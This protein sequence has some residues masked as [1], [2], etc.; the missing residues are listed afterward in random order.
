MKVIVMFIVTGF[1]FSNIP[2]I[3]L[4]SLSTALKALSDLQESK[5]EV[6]DPGSLRS[7]C[8]TSRKLQD[9]GAN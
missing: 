7:V 4:V 6:K 2:I 9:V 3:H 1:L 8:S 5:G